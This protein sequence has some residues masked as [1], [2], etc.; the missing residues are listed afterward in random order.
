MGDT[1]GLKILLY[2]PVFAPS[3]GGVETI[4]DTLARNLVALGHALTVVT[5]TPAEPTDEDESS[6]TSPYPFLLVR[7]PS[8][9]LRR[10]LVEACDIVHSNSASVAMVRHAKRAGKP[11]VWTHNGYQVSCVD[12]LGWVEGEAAPMT[13]LASLQFHSKCLG[14][15]PFLKECV[16]LY[17]RRH[18]AKQVVHANLAATEWVAHRQPLPRQ[19]VAYTP[20]ALEQFKKADAEAETEYDFIYVGRLVSEKGVPQLLEAFHRLV[21]ETE[22]RGASLLVVGDGNLRERLDAQVSSWEGAPRITFAGVQRGDDLVKAIEKADIAVVPS[23]WEEPMGGVSLELLAAG[24]CLIVSQRGGHAEI[25]GD[26]G[27]TFSNGNV[28]GL[29]QCMKRLMDEPELRNQLK[30]NAPKRLELFDERRLTERYVQIY[31][32][33]LRSVGTL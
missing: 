30:A 9:H 29:F 7:H 4:T 17:Y 13:P 16:K 14:F 10:Q 31:E 11:F 15:V 22:H 33:V 23:E 21:T 3:V 12:G 24:K 5:E 27:L 25:V 2:S 8:S 28:E 18:V 1:I 19:Q 26:A 32:E 20:Y 6:S